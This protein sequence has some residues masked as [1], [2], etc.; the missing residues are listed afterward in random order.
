MG[1]LGLDDRLYTFSPSIVACRFR[2]M[3]YICEVKLRCKA[4]T[5][6]L[7]F[8]VLI[9]LFDVQSISAASAGSKCSK[10]GV[11]QKTKGVTYTCV[12]T[13]K[14]LKW[15]RKNSQQ[16]ATTTSVPLSMTDLLREFV[17]GETGE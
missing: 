7:V 4:L 9:A 2:S 16:I 12:R 3:A 15:V 8:L 14:L 11:I 13:G 10:A 17:D 1:I 6:L 5:T